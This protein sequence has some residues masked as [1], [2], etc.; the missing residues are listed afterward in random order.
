MDKDKIREQIITLLYNTVRETGITRTIIDTADMYHLLNCHNN[1]TTDEGIELVS[2]LE[3]LSVD[4][5][6][7]ELIE[8]IENT[9]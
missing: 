6:N 7:D 5:L 8:K 1:Y 9:L 4:E 2:I 3:E